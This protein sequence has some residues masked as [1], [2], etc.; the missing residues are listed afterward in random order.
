MEHV[1][2]ER[3]ALRIGEPRTNLR[4]YLFVGV[5]GFLQSFTRVPMMTSAALVAHSSYTRCYRGP[6]S[7]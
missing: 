3:L 6:V 7:L 2:I 1:V 4:E 5:D